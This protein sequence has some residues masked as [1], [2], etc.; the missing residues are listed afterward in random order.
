MSNAE[1]VFSALVARG[2]PEHVA[3][4][5]VGNLAQE[6]GIKLDTRE[7][8]D[9]G[10]SFGM[11]QWNGPRAKAL[12]D[13]AKQTGR[14]PD[15]LQT[16]IDFMLNEF[17]TTERRAY[18]RMLA[19]K[20]PAEAARVA[21]EA[22]WRPRIPMMENRVRYGENAMDAF[23][24]RQAGQQPVQFTREQIDAE[25]KRR[26]VNVPDAGGAAPEEKKPEFTREEIE[27][28]L[29]LRGVMKPDKTLV[30]GMNEAGRMMINDINAG[31]Q[32]VNPVGAAQAPVIG[33]VERVGDKIFVD[34]D[35]YK[36]ELPKDWTSQGYATRID[37]Q[38]GL[39]LLF[40]KTEE[41]KDPTAASIGR[42]LGYT[43]PNAAP[44][45]PVAA[46]QSDA[47][48][49]AR[50]MRD[51]GVTPSLGM[52]GPG[53]ARAA[54]VM[55]GAL[56]TAS[57]AIDDATRAMREVSGVVED[58][59]ARIGQGADA[60]DAG[61]ALRSG[62]NTF[63]IKNI[64][65]NTAA[66]VTSKSQMLYD[67]VAQAIPA[68]TRVPATETQRF[69][70]G[71]LQRFKDTP[72]IA[73]EVGV[74]RWQGYLDDIAK[75]G[76][77]LSWDQA[78]ALRSELLAATRDLKGP[79]TG[80]SA[81]QIKQVTQTLTRDLEA[82]AK[83]AGPGAYRAWR[84]A[85]NHYKWASE[86]VSDALDIIFSAKSP[87]R[88]YE[89]VIALGKDKGASANIGK[90]T[91]IKRVLPEED[92]ATVV[93]TTVRQL[94]RASAG[95]QNAAGDVFSASAFLTNWNKLSPRAKQVLFSG[96]GVP[97]GLRQELDKL[98]RVV[99][100]AKSA[101]RQMNASRSG[102]FLTN[103]ALGTTLLADAATAGAIGAGSFLTAKA[104]TSP[105]FLRLLRAYTA[106]GGSAGSRQRLI[107]FAQNNADFANEVGAL[108]RIGEQSDNTP[109]T[110]TG[111]R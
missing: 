96:K 11:G 92:W 65:G 22:Y 2:I 80:V 49:A 77:T 66:N 94:G 53:G 95:G 28:E 19:T 56:P 23:G 43:M 102:S 38:S 21:S 84:N 69:L 78:S 83:A 25:L 73:R 57:T 70:D 64:N 4:G 100:T 98:A 7:V 15:D 58:T 37:P 27:R 18:E 107:R 88:A 67:R 72:N 71:I 24:G 20:T 33:V 62:A 68:G 1:A 82:A 85:S 61:T 74:S 13:F 44:R 40:K 47:A 36:Y 81:G 87:E 104:M 76:G 59:A 97:G 5:I 42:V 79:M 30:Q 41:I 105:R 48:V 16:Q 91:T 3:A 89:S 46:T 45:G 9:S 6:S 101:E 35:G 111:A 55:E 52:T 108:L 29:M 90:L 32:G 50:D 51:L 14:A 103:A 54:S 110:E 60:L 99:E 39:E 93:A 17:Q 26:G 86:K 109:R 10:N 75:N 31:F 8:G 12:F 106:S 63:L 34:S